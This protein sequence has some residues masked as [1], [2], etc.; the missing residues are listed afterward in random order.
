MAVDALVAF[1]TLPVVSEPL[2]RDVKCQQCGTR[3]TKGKV[4]VVVKSNN[5]NHSPNGNRFYRYIFCGNQC[6]KKFTDLAEEATV[7]NVNLDRRGKLS[8]SY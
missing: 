4:A 6:Y 3:I 7:K 8:L 1:P 5:C 2:K